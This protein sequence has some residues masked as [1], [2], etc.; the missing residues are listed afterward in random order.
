MFH[1]QQINKQ[2]LQKTLTF[3]KTDTLVSLKWQIL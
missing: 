3:Q 2:K 1:S